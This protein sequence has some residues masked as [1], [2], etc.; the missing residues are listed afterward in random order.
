VLSRQAFSL[1]LDTLTG[2]DFETRERKVSLV[3]RGGGWASET[4]GVDAR[5]AENIAE[6]FGGLRPPF[7]W[8]IG[9]PSAQEGFETP[10]LVV[11]AH[12]PS[13]FVATITVGAPHTFAG[14]AGYFARISGVDATF[15]L[16]EQ[17]V[18]QLLDLL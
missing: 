11:R 7:A 5:H 14:V 1:D 3:A 8:H 13:N 17:S 16:T 9:K 10:T 2:I 4:P 18:R 12:G 15:A 6:A